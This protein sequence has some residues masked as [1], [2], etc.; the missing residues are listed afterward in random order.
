MVG[1]MSFGV[2]FPWLIG[3]AGL[4]FCW[5]IGIVYWGKQVKKEKEQTKQ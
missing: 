5:Y 2:W 3:L 4:V 1:G